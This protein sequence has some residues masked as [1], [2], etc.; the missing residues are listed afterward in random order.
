M[1]EGLD[2]FQFRSSFLQWLVGRM[3][4]MGGVRAVQ[5]WREGPGGPVKPIFNLSATEQRFDT[6]RSTQHRKGV[7]G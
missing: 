5:R 6:Q 7:L 3:V 1:W 4:G 2:F